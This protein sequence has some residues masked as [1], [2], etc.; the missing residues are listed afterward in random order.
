MVDERESDTCPPPDRSDT[1]VDHCPSP[2]FKITDGM[3]SLE[4]NLDFKEWIIILSCI[5]LLLYLGLI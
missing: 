1:Q 3:K 5:A 2:D 4:V